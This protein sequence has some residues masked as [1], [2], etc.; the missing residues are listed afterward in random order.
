MIKNLTLEQEK[1]LANELYYGGGYTKKYSLGGFFEGNYDRTD[2]NREDMSSARKLTS[3]ANEK[4]ASTVGA[5]IGTVGAVGDAIGG[6]TGN[7]VGSAAKF[8]QMGMVAGPIGAGVGALIG[9]GLGIVQNKKRKK[10]EKKQEQLMENKLKLAQFES[11]KA[12]DFKGYQDGGVVENNAKNK[13]S[14]SY[15]GKEEDFENYNDY[16]FDKLQKEKEL[17]KLTGDFFKYDFL[18]EFDNPYM[19]NT[20]T[21]SVPLLQTDAER[22]DSFVNR[23]RSKPVTPQM[24]ESVTGPGIEKMRFAEKFQTGGMTKGAYSHSANPLKVVD[25]KGQDTGMELTGGEGV[26]DKPFMG[27]LQGLLSGGRYQEA[28]KAVQNEMKTWKH[29]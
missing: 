13:Y 18:K 8:A 1:S 17:E 15:T 29:K 25:K 21:N 3:F 16:M 23:D 27:K 19:D 20:R 28:G 2:P 10:E 22:L 7:V 4:T 14:I 26:F 12:Q 5:G 24:L 9:A 11:E 6:D